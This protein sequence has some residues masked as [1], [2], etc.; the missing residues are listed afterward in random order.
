MQTRDPRA[1]PL[2]LF[3]ALGLAAI[4][5]H[6][7]HLCFLAHRLNCDPILLT[8]QSESSGW[9]TNDTLSYKRVGD[10]ILKHRSLRPSAIRRPPAYSVLLSLS[11]SL[12]GTIEALRWLGPLLAGGAAAAASALGWSISR[13][14]SAALLA[15]CL[16]LAWPTAYQFSPLLLSDA[17]HAFLAL[18]AFSATVWWRESESRRAAVAAALLW[19]MAQALRPT[20]LMLPFLLPWLLVKRQGSR[21]YRSVCVA[22]LLSSSVVPLLLCV[23]NYH[24]HGVF[25]PSGVFSENLACYAAMRLR[26]EQGEGDFATLRDACQQRFLGYRWRDRIALQQ[27]EAW[28]LF[29]SRRVAAIRSHLFEIQAQL[30]SAARLFYK[31]ELALLYPSWLQLPASAMA[32]F[33]LAAAGSVVAAMRNHLGISAF[34]LLACVSVLGPAS[35]SHLVGAR[36]RLPVD[37]LVLPFVAVSCRRLFVAA[38]RVLRSRC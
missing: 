32:A 23:S 18:G 26:A 12:T 19:A 29:R 37:L 33:W 14:R 38:S 17:P 13:S 21:S 16:F 27:Q 4:A 24:R 5:L 35:T 9:T 28:Q 31:D 11:E 7:A 6:A 15:G 10:R 22:L 20:F 2:R 8:C 1:P 25:V 34:A 30:G 36:L 3:L